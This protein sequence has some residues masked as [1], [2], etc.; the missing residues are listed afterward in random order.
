MLIMLKFWFIQALPPITRSLAW[1]TCKHQMDNLTYLYT[2]LSCTSWSSCRIALS[3]GSRW[4]ELV[5]MC[6]PRTSDLRMEVNSLKVSRC[7]RWMIRG[8][9]V[10]Y[11]MTQRPS[12]N[13]LKHSSLVGVDKFSTFFDLKQKTLRSHGSK[14][15]ISDWPNY[16]R[17]KTL[18]NHLLNALKNSPLTVIVNIL[19]FERERA[20]NEHTT[21]LI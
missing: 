8:L 18:G 11:N 17:S 14:T 4:L 21:R 1:N 3:K 2:S 13:A 5:P 6:W 15:I 19:T 7:C 10:S 16:N 20:K 12:R 9:N